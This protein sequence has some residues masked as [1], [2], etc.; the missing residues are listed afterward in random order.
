MKYTIKMGSSAMTYV[1]SFIKTGSTIV[2]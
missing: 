2:T 1:P